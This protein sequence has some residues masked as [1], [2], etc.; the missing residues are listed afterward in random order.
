[1][2]LLYVHTRIGFCCNG[3]VETQTKFSFSW[4][5]EKT[6]RWAADIS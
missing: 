3:F 2:N 5:T 6:V 1:M 4:R